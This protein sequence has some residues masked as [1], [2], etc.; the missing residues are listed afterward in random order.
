[1]W[2]L[3]NK[4]DQVPL[5]S[6]SSRKLQSA[7]NSAEHPKCHNAFIGFAG[8]S[9]EIHEHAPIKLG[10]GGS[11]DWHAEAQSHVPRSITSG[12]TRRGWAS[13]WEKRW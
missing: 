4:S 2:L 7:A 5:D 11:E 13:M 9:Q 6:S 1:L 10:H 12:D 3:R 8:I